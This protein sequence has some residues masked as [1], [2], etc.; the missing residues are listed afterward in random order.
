VINLKSSLRTTPEITLKTK[1]KN[2]V[3]NERITTE[4]QK[5]K[6]FLIL[7]ITP[8]LQIEIDVFYHRFG[9]FGNGIPGHTTREPL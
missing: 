2:S 7:L 9:S 5:D 4:Q 3:K 8:R 6:L 1:K